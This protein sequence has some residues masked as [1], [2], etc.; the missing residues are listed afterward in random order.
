MYKINVSFE[1]SDRM[2][3]LLT[4]F[5]E[6][7]AEITADRKSMP[8]AMH[9]ESSF[10]LERRAEKMRYDLLLSGYALSLEQ[11]GE[12]LRQSLGD[13]ASGAADEAGHAQVESHGTTSLLQTDPASA[14]RNREIQA[15]RNMADV[16]TKGRGM[17]LQLPEDICLLHSMLFTGIADDAG[18]FRAAEDIP[19]AM[20]SLCDWYRKS[21]MQPLLRSIVFSYEILRIQPFSS[22]NEITAWSC[23]NNQLERWR[24]ILSDL[25]YE[26][27]LYRRKNEYL[28]VMDACSRSE[29]PASYVEFMLRILYSA[30]QVY[31]EELHSGLDITQSMQMLLDAMEDGKSYTTHEMMALVNL[32]HRPTFRDNYLLPCIE[33]GLIVMTVPDKPNSRNQR[34]RKL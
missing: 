10:S 20:R 5:A 19:A 4:D 31:D 33:G 23:L 2:I 3:C 8:M 29:S 34:Y 26:T 24:D 25:S 1:I 22:G 32:R 6:Y 21:S 14:F 15:A 11:A 9:K 27:F 28:R 18:H 13:S 30:L 17:H 12:Y 16:F 7:M